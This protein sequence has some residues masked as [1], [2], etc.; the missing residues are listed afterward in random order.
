MQTAE[1]RKDGDA[2]TNDAETE[3]LRPPLIVE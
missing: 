2:A 1:R 3:L